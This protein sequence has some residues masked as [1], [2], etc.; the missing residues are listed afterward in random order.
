MHKLSSVPMLLTYRI[1]VLH[2][3][4]TRYWSH[5]ESLNINIPIFKI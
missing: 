5:A 1:S 2:T 3:E 4:A